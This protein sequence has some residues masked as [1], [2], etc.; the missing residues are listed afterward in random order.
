MKKS[1][2]WF[3]IILFWLLV[4]EAAALAVGSAL[5][6]PGPVDVVAALGRL[7]AETQFYT[8]V[9]ATVGR[10]LLAMLLAVVFG[11]LLALASYR[12][13]LVRD[14]LSLPVA[15]FKAVPVMAVAI[16]MLLLLTSG[17]VP[18]LVCWVMCFPIV[19]TN[20]LA[21][22]DSMDAKLL[23]MAD[24]YGIRG[25]LR[26]RRVYAPML[27]PHFKSAMSIIAGM[28]WKAVVTAE[29][30]SVPK[31][32]L[33]YELMNSKYYLNTDDLFAYVAVI[34]AVSVLFE[35]LIKKVLDKCAPHEYEGSRVGEG[36]AMVAASAKNSHI[37]AELSHVYKSYGDKLVLDDFSLKLAEG[38]V[39]ALMGPSGIGKTTVARLLCGLEQPDAGEVR[40]SPEVAV[41]FQE[42]RLLPWLNV[43]DNLAIVGEVRTAGSRIWQALEAV[44][45][46]D[47]AWKLPTQ[48]SGG[49][50]HRLA[51]ARALLYDAALV[52]ADEPFRGLDEETRRQVIENLW[53]P[54]VEGRTVLLITHDEEDAE[55]L[56]DLTVT[57]QGD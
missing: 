3:L 51:M 39:T 57:I 48:L 7:V 32:S 6:L 20:L 15:F 31:F 25:S 34:I 55:D 10:C 24:V 29:V 41:L 47:E 11:F 46:Q 26:V 33:G 18:V 16:Y 35:K 54:G 45:L 4:W 2:K 30:L 21:G 13:Q 12:W 8:D 5:L 1:V 9:A 23:E 53:K 42:D 28:S 56:A 36:S 38:K 37:S 52:I 43:Y 40:T 50:S 17:S 49:M 27:Y 19:Y 22:L 44:G 14:V